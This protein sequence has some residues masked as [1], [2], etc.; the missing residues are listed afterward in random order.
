[1]PDKISKNDFIEIEFTGRVK[2]TDE[3]FD[4]NIKEDAEKAELKIKEFKPFILAVGHNMLLKGF[5]KELEGRETEQKYSS[6][7]SPENAFG[8]RN[9]SLVK[10]IPLKVFHEQKIMP[11][12]GMQ[13][14]MD[15]MV[16]KILSSSGGRVLVDFNNPLAGK[17]VVYDYKINR[18]I[19]DINEK[20][21]SLQD[22]FFRKKFDFAL[23]E[24]DL[25]FKVD[26]KLSKFIELM[27]KPFE[28]ILG[29]KVKVEEIKEAPKEEKEKKKE[30]KTE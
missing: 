13:L 23:K 27:A 29:L 19:E 15:G 18:K 7:F 24:K 10:M 26:E 5:D 6:E 20:I 1:M 21:N 16:V 17:S 22:F 28:D 2:D 11:Q 4:T 3:I 8:K 9:P 12:A 14:S 25:V 30:E